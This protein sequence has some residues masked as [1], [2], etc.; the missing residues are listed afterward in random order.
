MFVYLFVCP[1]QFSYYNNPFAAT[2]F[3][4]ETKL[5]TWQPARY[6]M[7]SYYFGLGLI[8]RK[9]IALN[10][11]MWKKECWMT[12]TEQNINETRNRNY[13]VFH[14]YLISRLNKLFLGN[15]C[16]QTSCLG[17]NRD[18]CFA[19]WSNEWVKIT[20]SFRCASMFD[21]KSPY[22]ECNAQHK[23]TTQY[24]LCLV[25]C[26]IFVAFKSEPSFYA[27]QINK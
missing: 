26:I 14:A 11:N 17:K 12:E 15:I 10:N 25:F 6:D 9:S 27:Y 22:Y 13:R 4:F 8:F 5:F 19:C 1:L 24:I 18:W 3:V 20:L 23:Y 7:D 21:R 16:Q 2:N